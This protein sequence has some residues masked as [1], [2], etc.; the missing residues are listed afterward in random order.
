MTFPAR[1]IENDVRALWALA[2]NRVRS[3]VCS[4]VSKAKTAQ[5]HEKTEDGMNPED[6]SSLP[7]GFCL[8]VLCSGVLSPS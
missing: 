8:V 5:R 3:N 7:S 2:V 4:D 6:A 1:N